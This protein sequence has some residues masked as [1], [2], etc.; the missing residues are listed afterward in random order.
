MKK[1]KKT[2]D[3][4]KYCS[5]KFNNTFIYDDT[6]YIAS[7]KNI[8]YICP[9]HGL[10]IQIARNHK[11]NKFGC[12]LCSKDNMNRH[13]KTTEEFILESKKIYSIKLDYDLT[14]YINKRTKVKLRCIEHDYIFKQDPNSHLKGMNG[15]QICISNK[16]SKNKLA[17]SE[18]NKK[19]N[20]K[21]ITNL[22]LFV[23]KAKV[24]YS[25]HYD[26]NKVIFINMKTKVIIKC[27]IHDVE[28]KIAP[29]D[30]IHSQN[31]CTL[32]GKEKQRK[33]F[34]KNKSDWI[35]E[36]I[37]VHNNKYDYS[38]VDYKDNRTKIIIIC[39]IHGEFT[40]VPNKHVNRGDGCPNCMLENRKMTL[41]EFLIN[42][43]K[44]HN[45]KYDYSNTKLTLKG[46]HSYINYHCLNC[47]MEVLQRVDG[48]LSGDGCLYCS[49]K[50]KD[51]SMWVNKAKE[52]HGNLYDY[53]KVDYK[54][55]NEEVEI[56]CKKHKSFFQLP[57]LH[58]NGSGCPICRASKGEK[59]I[60][61]YL[62]NNNIIYIHDK[63]YISILNK[64]NSKENIK[65]LR[66]DFFIPSKNIFI[67][68]DGAQHFN[69]ASFN[70]K[71]EGSYE[72][73]K[74]TEQTDNIKN[75]LIE[76]LDDYELIRIPFW[77][78]NNIENILDK[79]LLI[80]KVSQVIL[81]K[82]SYENI[83]NIFNKKL[84]KH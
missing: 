63:A 54:K 33:Q 58:L 8:T 12:K 10:Q 55:F 5:N 44:I 13:T 23:K 17:N 57:T 70:T 31:G 53:E 30:F 71:R 43:K 51:T 39:P 69:S 35:Q 50:I 7:S 75:N 11:R 65:R 68:F 15:C 61:N 49:G 32:C 82:Y 47:N 20:I 56:I 83:Q 52:V 41:K 38:K 36:S 18:Y 25:E 81:F 59:K 9:I 21:R 62:K 14:K 74:R 76:S 22:E 34:V 48:H 6:I 84:T 73:F 42:A 16:I 46:K 3:F 19:K 64:F 79:I 28:F 24:L 78:I 72:K 27:N 2:L 29:T 37:A 67:E 4:I 1:D 26:Y 40:Q 45:E 60:L 80:D 66:F 77:D